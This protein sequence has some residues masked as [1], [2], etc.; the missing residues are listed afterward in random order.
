MLLCCLLFADCCLR[1]SLILMAT[2][3]VVQ[4]SS[5]AFAD[6]ARLTVIENMFGAQIKYLIFF[7]YFFENNVFVY[8][9]F[10]QSLLT[11]IYLVRL[12]NGTLSVCVLCVCVCV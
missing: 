10:V 9:F 3:P 5:Q 8:I 12:D 1:C 4:F 2:I 6:Y 11:L 7:K